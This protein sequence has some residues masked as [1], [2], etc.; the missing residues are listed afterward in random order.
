[1][2]VDGNNAIA[3]PIVNFLNSYNHEWILVTI[4][5]LILFFMLIIKPIIFRSSKK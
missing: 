5:F 2:L 4:D 3:E 1:M